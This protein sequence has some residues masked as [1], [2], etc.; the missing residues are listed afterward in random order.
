MFYG[1][2]YNIPPCC[3]QKYFRSLFE[4]LTAAHPT[5][6][7]FMQADYSLQMVLSKVLLHL[8]MSHLTIIVPTINESLVNTLRTALSTSWYNGK[9][10]QSHMLDRLT[11]ITSHESYKNYARDAN[12]PDAYDGTVLV[13]EAFK[14]YG[15]RVTLAEAESAQTMFT[16]QTADKAYAFTGTAAFAA[17]TAKQ[18]LT[19]LVATCSPT[20]V[21]EIS[22]VLRL[23]S[24]NKL[25]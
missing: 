18:C 13:R 16:V 15:W 9:D 5:T 19:S 25:Q 3:D 7:M 6:C 20:H 11:L 2:E 10:Y 1:N 21:K 8:P 22:T 23:L 24:H 17:T 12:K 4:S 14:P